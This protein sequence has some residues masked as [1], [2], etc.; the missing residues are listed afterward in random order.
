MAMKAASQVFRKA[1]LDRLA[2]PEQLDELIPVVDARGWIAA[3]GIGVLTAAVIAWGFLGSIPTEVLAHGILVTQGGRVVSALS[4]TSGVV[5]SL[6][7]KPGD[8]VRRGQ[9]VAT[10]HQP[11]AELRLA[12]AGQVEA[13]R[14]VT[15]ET[16]GAAL[17][18]EA[19]AL[20]ANA[21][22]RKRAQEQ[23]IEQA[24]ERIGRLRRQLEIRE[25]MHPRNLALEERVEQARADLARAQQDVSD[26]RARMVEIDT[27]LLHSRLEAERELAGLRA[28]LAD[29]KRAAAEAGAALTATRDVV[30]PA[31][32]KVTELAVSEGQ[33]VTAN[34][35]VLNVE[36]EGRR[37][38]AVVY[39]PTE[40]GKQVSVGMA[41]RIALST[42][43]MR[44]WGALNGRVA[45]ISDFPATPQGMAAVLGNPQLVQS[46][47][48]GS[49]PYEARIDLQQADTPSGYAWSSGTGPTLDL[50]SGTTLSAAI[51]VR[52]EPPINLVLPSLRQATG[53]TR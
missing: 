10:I 42:V 30:A 25:Q 37:L 52:E 49:A 18:R 4:P 2:S 53:L 48:G 17:Q 39:V 9:P 13:E 36:T 45:S 43:K 14:A 26:A 22:Q 40:H 29:A 8:A 6:T 19:Q 7:V 27:E 51:A 44:E 12:N 11:E 20:E 5:A 35:T 23:I 15:L 46:F 31:T 3:L 50:S 21:T 33:M 28:G 47:G 24:N 1:A 34:G 16:R 38:Q 32:G 41:A